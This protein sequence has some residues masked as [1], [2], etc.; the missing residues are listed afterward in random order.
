MIRK[1]LGFAVT[2][3][4]LVLG[5]SHSGLA[6]EKDDI[7]RLSREVESLKEG[8][9]SLQKDLQEIKQLLQQRP[10]P[11]PQARQAAVEPVDAALVVGDDAVKGDPKAKVVVVEFSDYQ[12]PF[13]KRHVQNTL[14]Q[15]DKEYVATGRVRYVFRDF[16]LE[17]IHPQAAKAS[18]AAYCAGEQGKYWEMH[19]LLFANQQALKIENLLKYGETAKLDGTRFKGCLEVGKYGDKVRQNAAEGRRLGISGTPTS[20]VGVAGPDGKL[21]Q[22]KRIRGAQPFSVFKQEIDAL[23]MAT[24]S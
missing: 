16:P 17:G 13:C 14:S 22:I 12:C 19:E 8:Q 5:W 4:A 2:A 23:L 20:F 6:A 3:M 7:E 10:Q 1:T 24:G 21:T 18:E 11:S 9:K 15:L